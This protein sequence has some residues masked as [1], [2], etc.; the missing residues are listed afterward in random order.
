MRI[1]VHDDY[2]LNYWAEKFS[3]SPEEV[4]DAVRQLGDDR[5]DKV[6]EYLE[7]Q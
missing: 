4:E 3:V 6:Q 5:V 1:N 2:E 7:H